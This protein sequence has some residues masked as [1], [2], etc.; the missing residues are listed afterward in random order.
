MYEP[1]M[2]VSGDCPNLVQSSGIFQTEGEGEVE[3]EMGRLNR[4]I[5]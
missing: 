3:V 4:W 2:G 1:V 5:L